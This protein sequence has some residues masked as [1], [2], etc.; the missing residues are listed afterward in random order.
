MR[1]QIPFG[2]DNKKKQKQEPQMKS[3]F[4]AGAQIRCW[5]LQ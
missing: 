2:N 3:S 1:Q 4:A 5:W